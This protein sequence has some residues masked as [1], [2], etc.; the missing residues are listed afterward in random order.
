MAT[1]CKIV[2]TADEQLDASA[3]LK[4]AL[5][6]AGQGGLAGAAAMAIN[7]CSLMWMRTTINYQ[8]RYGIPTTEAFKAL[9]KEGGIPRFYRGIVPALVQGP[10]SRFGDTAANAGTIA[11]LDSMDLT[12]DLPVG[13]KTVAASTAAALFRILLMP[14]DTFKTSMQVGGKDGLKNLFAKVKSKGPTVFWY[15]A[16][17]SASATFVGH[18]P[19]FFTYNF[20]NEKLPTYDDK[21]KTLGRSAFIGFCSS[22][23]SDTCSNSIR[24]IK[25]YKQANEEAITYPQA[26]KRVIAEDGVMGLLGRGLKT[27]IMA[28]GM[29]GLMFSVLWKYIDDQFFKKEK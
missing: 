12:K 2:A 19:W 8:Y 13:V 11:A 9:Y 28:N 4:K 15:G 27:K 10:L 29:Q 22:A 18:Y 16:L 20:L 17:A 25:V 14:V 6:R 24:V 5:K 3:V 7:V 1:T 26:L 23:V 21:L